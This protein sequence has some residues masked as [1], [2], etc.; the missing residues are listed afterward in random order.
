MRKKNPDPR[1]M[2]AGENTMAK[3]AAASVCVPK[4]LPICT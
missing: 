1:L 3:Q 4:V 2:H